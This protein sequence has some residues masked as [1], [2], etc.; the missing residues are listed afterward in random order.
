M[1]DKNKKTQLY[2]NIEERINLRKLMMKETQ[3]YTT[4]EVIKKY[5]QKYEKTE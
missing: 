2:K 4:K 1:K 5:C 3:I